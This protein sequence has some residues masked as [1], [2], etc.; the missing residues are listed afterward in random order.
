MKIIQIVPTLPPAIDGLGDYAL[1]LARQ[2]RQGFAQETHFVVGNPAWE[3]ERTIEGF[4]I[5]VLPKR[6]GAAV[7]SSLL[8]VCSSP[9]PVLLHY[10]GYG[11]AKR[12][13]PLWLVDG[14]Q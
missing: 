11:Y 3:G 8:K 7:L 1:N 12:G 6:S 14:L 10:V 4:P 13:C 5:T 2:L 9:A